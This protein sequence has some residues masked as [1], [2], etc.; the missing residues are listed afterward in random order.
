[1]NLLDIVFLILLG[2]SGW[3]GFKK[4]FVIEIF[5]F[6]ALFAGLYAGILF[7]DWLSRIIIEDFGSDSKYVPIISF[8]IIFI[9]VGAMVYYVGKLVERLIKVVRLTPLN[10]AAGLFFGALKMAFY[11]G[12]GLILLE[13]YDERS[14][15]LSEETKAGSLL[16]HPMKDMTRAC[17]PAF[18]ESTLVLKN[19]LEVIEDKLPEK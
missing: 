18:D 11:L 19:T 2:L 12:A 16:Y 15:I 7:S 17:I 14:D 4:G 13:S 8:A 3:N 5:G 1:M 6:I 10:K 9:A